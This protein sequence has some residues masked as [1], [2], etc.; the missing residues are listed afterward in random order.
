MP[1]ISSIGEAPVGGAGISDII[2]IADIS[3]PVLRVTGT[4]IPPHVLSATLPDL[5]F[6]ARG[7]AVSDNT[8]PPL[9]VR[10]EG[11]DASGDRLA[12]VALPLLQ[13]A[14]AAGANIRATLPRLSAATTGT[15]TLIATV[16]R[17]L[18]TLSVSAA[19]TVT[20]FGHATLQLPALEAAAAAC[21]VLCSVTI[22]NVTVAATGTTGRVGNF[23]ITLP[24]LDVVSSATVGSVAASD[25]T[26]PAFTI[27]TGEHVAVSLPSLSLVAIGH[28]VVAVTYEAY[29]LNIKHSGD[30]T[31]DELTRYTNY[32][33]TQIVRYKGSYY[34]MNSAG[35]YL[36]EGTTDDG[37][38]IAWEFATHITDFGSQKLKTVDRAYFGGRLGP[39]ATVTLSVGETADN[40]YS[41]TTPR[42]QTA[43]NYRQ[44]F[45][46]GAKAR[47]F[48]IGASGTDALELDS[49][50]LAV[51]E[52]TRR[53]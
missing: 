2:V 10:A 38:D 23:R 34:G 9:G 3:L 21:G 4:N 12:N 22:G 8:L 13:F 31:N 48:S 45:G 25:I 17:T 53:I 7:G 30:K 49:L 27:R 26:L 28:A 32:P 44:V 5:T 20:N 33:F 16:A 51:T 35:L 29:A 18:P 41:Y 43:Q 46:K 39:D 42:G 19:G 47:Y 50:E 36:L 1:G 6:S 15:V 24:L 14:A 52:L 40:S 11:H 37:D